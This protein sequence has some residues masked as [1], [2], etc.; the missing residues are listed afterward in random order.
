MMAPPNQRAVKPSPT[1]LSRPAGGQKLPRE[2]APAQTRPSFL[3]SGRFVPPQARWLLRQHAA[4]LP[5]IRGH[6]ATTR[7]FA[8]A[9]GF[10]NP[11]VSWHLA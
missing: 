7:P 5:D 9:C 1:L 10:F 2:N 8:V 3:P 6:F 11:I 4:T